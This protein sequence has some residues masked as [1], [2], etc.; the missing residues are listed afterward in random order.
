MDTEFCKVPKTLPRNQT[1]SSGKDQRY[2][3]IPQYTATTSFYYVAEKPVCQANRPQNPVFLAKLRKIERRC[4]DREKQAEIGS[5]DGEIEPRL[6]GVALC[7]FW[8]KFL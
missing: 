1:C 8:A 2:L 5:A 4:L 7:F 3:I 6:R